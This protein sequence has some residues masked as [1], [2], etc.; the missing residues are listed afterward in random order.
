MIAATSHTGIPALPMLGALA[1]RLGSTGVAGFLLALATVSALHAPLHAQTAAKWM[2]RASMPI[3]RAETGAARVGDKIYVAAGFQGGLQPSNNLQA[4]TPGK[5]TWEQLKNLPVSLHHTAMASAGGKLYVMGGVVNGPGGAHPNGAEWTGSTHALEYNPATDTWKALKPLPQ[6]TAAAG[7]VSHGGKIYVIGGISADGI[8]LDNVQVYDP[9]I[10]TWTSKT[11]MPTQREHVGAAVLG[12]LIYIVSGR[13]GNNS[14]GK[15]EAYNVLT[16]KWTTLAPMPTVRSDIGF[17][18]SMGK[19][20]AFGGEKPGIFDVNEEYDPAAN[21]WK[22]VLKMTGTRKA[23]S[24]ASFDDTLFVF[25]GF[26]ANGTTG[27]VE[28]F[29]PP[30]GIS[31]AIKMDL[32]GSGR[33]AGRESPAFGLMRDALGRV[34]GYSKGRN[35]PAREGSSPHV[36]RLFR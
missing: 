36:L 13:V 17:G 6:S 14:M 8:T 11:K 1:T 9:A 15:L 32:T 7:V 25:G 30:G 12:D 10:D 26:S 33:A 27:T 3:L 31:T 23:M 19:L 22:T 28:A 35:A 20:Y 2:S 21:S 5:N 34:P 29:T 18:V 16:D 24:V 4:Y